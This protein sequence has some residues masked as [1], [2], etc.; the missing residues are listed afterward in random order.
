M[1]ICCA[2][3]A[4]ARSPSHQKCNVDASNTR[5][6]TYEETGYWY[7]MERACWKLCCG[8]F[9]NAAV[10]VLLL[11]QDECGWSVCCVCDRY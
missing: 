7:G 11:L 5:S 9:K 1:H 10:H 6:R 8:H 2:V 3:C 4:I